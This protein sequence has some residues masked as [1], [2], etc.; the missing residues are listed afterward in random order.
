[1]ALRLVF[2]GTPEF[3]VPTLLEILGSGHGGIEN[4]V[5]WLCLGRHLTN[6]TNAAEM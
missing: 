4:A 2:M 5:L 6:F 3:A 1:M